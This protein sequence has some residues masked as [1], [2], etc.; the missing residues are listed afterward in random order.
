[1]L[2]RTAAAYIV[3]TGLACLLI[4]LALSACSSA[5]HLPAS[6]TPSSRTGSP[7]GQ[8]E[9]API[10]PAPAELLRLVSFVDADRVRA[11]AVYEAALPHSHVAPLA[12]AAAFSPNYAPGPGASVADAAYA[13]YAFIVPAFTGHEITAGWL[14]PPAAANA[15]IALGNYASGR[16]DWFAL[17]IA[18]PLE[19][20]AFDDYLAPGTGT[21]FA[22]V[23]VS[24]TAQADLAWLRLGDNVPPQAVL[25][26]NPASG[27]RPLTVDFDTTGSTDIDGSIASY[28]W[29]LNGDGIF[30]ET[31]TP[32]ATKQQ[33]YDTAGTYDVKVRVVDNNGAGSVAIKSIVVEEPGREP[34][35]AMLS[36]SP[37]GGSAPLE[38]DFDASASYENGGTIVRYEW[39]WEGD[40]TYDADTGATPTA[41]HTYDANGVYQATVRVWDDINVSD[42][43][44]KTISVGAANLPPD[45]AFSADVYFGD[46]PLDVT[47]DAS[48]SSDTDGTI[49]QYEWDWDGDGTYDQTTAVPTVSHTYAAGKVETIMRVTDDDG[50]T[51][52]ASTMITADTPGY[53]EVE[54]NDSAS[55]PNNLPRIAF[56]GWEGN[57]GEGGYD[58][59]QEDW[60]R[61]HVEVSA[62]VALVMDFLHADADLDMRL[63]A[64]DGVTELGA[65]TG[66]K[67]QE[68]IV[69]QLEPGDYIWKCYR[70]ASSAGIVADYTLAV[71]FPQPPVAELTADPTSGAM[72][73]SVT[74]DGSGSHDDAGPISLYEWDLDGD[75]SYESS[76]SSATTTGIYYR[77]GAYQAVLRVTGAGGATATDDVTI[78][79]NSVTLD[80]VENNDDTA[81]ANALPAFPFGSYLG[82]LGPGGYDGDDADWYQFTLASPGTIDLT[83]LLY[84][85]FGDLDMKLYAADGTTEKGSS[86]GTDNDENINVHLDPGT[87]YWKCYVYSPDGKKYGGYALSASFTAD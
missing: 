64:A 45:A 71:E 25:D 69:K 60:Y 18:A 34:P 67:D 44:A 54:N 46:A 82:D 23:L 40:G 57:L 3:L 81:Q 68:R 76:G 39:D 30:E 53:D 43:D 50:A 1:M 7:L 61:F 41:S 24:G 65:S 8:P 31:G 62:D 20:G 6:S 73:L 33:L 63:Y 51:D 79:V 48:A 80:E 86:T 70:Y 12:T 83:M 38:V 75:G 77:A 19:V 10:L 47:F 59:D 58:G 26:G 22:V 13:T 84:D 11:G 55:E 4:A 37:Q 9:L 14:T 78:N 87:Y 5:A 16:W 35:V 74:F 56:S 21:V 15:W 72:P 27:S 49:V 42:T 85:P 28:D 29:D 32:D 66:T 17:P 2:R 36:A 52:S